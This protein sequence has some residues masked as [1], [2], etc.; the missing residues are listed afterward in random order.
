[1]SSLLYA[2]GRA[3]YRGRR[4]VV[5]GWAVVLLLVVASAGL[6]STGTSNSFVI[7]GTPSQAALDSLDTRFP[8]ASGAQAQMVVL[9]PAGQS[10]T[11]MKS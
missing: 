4:L 3:A 1:M 2:V 7:P 6:L 5:A 8:E 10:I 11:G 9:A